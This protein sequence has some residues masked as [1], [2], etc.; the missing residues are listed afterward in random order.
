[1]LKDGHD[2]IHVQALDSVSIKLFEGDRLGIIG[3]NGSGKTTLLK[4]IAGIYEPTGGTVMASGE[5]SSMIDL[6]CGMDPEATGVENIKLVGRIRGFSE[7][8]I[9]QQ[10]E[11]IISF[12]DLGP[13]I[14]LPVKTYSAGMQMRLLFAIGTC[15]VPEILIL[16]EWLG[17]GDAGFVAK[18]EARME[19]FVTGSKLLII[20][21]HNHDLIRRRCNKICV[22]SGGKVEFFGSTKEY[23]KELAA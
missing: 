5:I 10:I 8:K 23:F 12:A 11:E 16:D 18:A 14:D 21:S 7:Q 6:G 9:K 15:F 4:V 19:D 3:H 1:M 17:A 20:A 2:V 22:M 13:F